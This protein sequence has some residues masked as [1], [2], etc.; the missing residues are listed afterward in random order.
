MAT[1]AH[2][3]VSQKK[4]FFSDVA[5]DW[6]K[7]AVGVKT[8]FKTKISFSRKVQMVQS[9]IMRQKLQNNNVPTSV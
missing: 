3:R 9:S 8:N 4:L 5:V 6:Q 2:S 1:T 7:V